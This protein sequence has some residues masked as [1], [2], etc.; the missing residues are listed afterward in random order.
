MDLEIQIKSITFSIFYGMT[1]SLLFNLFHKILVNKKNRVVN[2]IIT[3][4]FVLVIC[5]VFFMFL[6]K[7]NNGIIN[8]YFIISVLI[9]FIIGNRKTKKIRYSFYK[10]KK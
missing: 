2:F 6:Y 9:G 7:I 4:V 3:L 5:T 10:N 8:Y 1:I